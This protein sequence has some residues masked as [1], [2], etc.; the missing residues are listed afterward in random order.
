MTVSHED[1]PYGEGLRV[2]IKDQEVR[3]CT[4]CD[5]EEVVFHEISKTHADLAKAIAKKPGTLTPAEVRFLRTF[6]GWSSRDLAAIMKVTPETV[7]RWERADGKY[8]IGPSSELALRLMALTGNRVKS[9]LRERAQGE[10]T[11]EMR[12]MLDD[13]GGTWE[14][15]PTTC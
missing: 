3:R 11:G 13:S 1:R 12:L 14:P 15:I 7:S 4:E 6:I 5:E 10:C 2:V 9:Y 8:K